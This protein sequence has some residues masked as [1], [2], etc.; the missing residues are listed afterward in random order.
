MFR[1][2]E[3]IENLRCASCVITRSV[4]LRFSLSAH[5][6]VHVHFTATANEFKIT[7][8]VHYNQV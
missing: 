8:G 5:M 7:V 4:F 6:R 2:T 3:E 1:A